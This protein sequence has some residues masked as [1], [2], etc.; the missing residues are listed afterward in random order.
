MKSFLAIQAAVFPVKE[1]GLRL[2]NPE[3]IRLFRFS[4]ILTQ[5]SFKCANIGANSP[6]CSLPAVCT[7]FSL[8]SF[9]SLFLRATPL[10]ARSAP[11]RGGISHF[12]RDNWGVAYVLK[13]FH[14]KLF[15]TLSDKFTV[16]LWYSICICYI[17]LYF[18][19]K[20]IFLT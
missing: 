19:M 14:R 8:N 18:H 4:P 20:I 3:F 5:S 1:I 2:E 13:S 7:I 12:V 6:S 11:R 17:T 15:T 10:K 9:T 16:L